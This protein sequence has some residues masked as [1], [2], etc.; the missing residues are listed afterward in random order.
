MLL[1][2]T[3]I[4]GGLLLLVFGADRF[5][6][7]AA[8]TA[9]HLGLSPL[10]IGMTVVGM[11]TSA[12]ELLVGVVAALQ[13]KT[14][15]AIGNAIG[16]NIV[17]VGLVLGGTVLFLPLAA[18]SK[19]LR[20]EILLMFLSIIVAFLLSID[21]RLSR[22]DGLILVLVLIASIWWTVKLAQSTSTEDPLADELKQELNTVVPFRRSLVPLVLGLILL[23]AGAELLVRGSVFVAKSF[24]ISDLVIGLTIIAIGTSLPELAASVISAVKNEADIAIG[25]VIGSN[26]FNMLMVMGTPSIIHPGV[27]GHEVL[28]RDFPIMILLTL[29]MGRK[30]LISG[31]GKFTRIDGGV[32]V[33]CFIAYQAFLF[34]SI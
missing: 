15:I 4:A 19:T 9:R 27:F 25:N 24:G 26:M 29:I 22:V 28:I 20:R 33:S 7:G 1:A 23:L 14:N 21:H 17:N 2:L 34:F 12:P 6:T 31:H 18:T 30:V 5:V 16:S 13:G 8:Q 11:A 32:L 10:I 3:A